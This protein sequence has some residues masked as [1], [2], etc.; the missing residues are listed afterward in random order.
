MGMGIKQ[1]KWEWIPI[2]SVLHKIH[3][4]INEKINSGRASGHIREMAKCS[5]YLHLQL[6]ARGCSALLDAFERKGGRVWRRV[7]S[8]VCCSYNSNAVRAETDFNV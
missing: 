8:T 2:V 1:W 3:I 4:I 6:R 5:A 7:V